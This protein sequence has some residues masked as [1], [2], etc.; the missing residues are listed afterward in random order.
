MVEKN[1][2]LVAVAGLL[3]VPM[4]QG[5]V[6][7]EYDSKIDVVR[8]ETHNANGTYRYLFTI[9]NNDTRP[10]WL[11]AVYTD[12]FE[13]RDITTS[14][15]E[16]Q[17]DDLS[18]EGLGDTWLVYLWNDDYP[19]F[20]ALDVGETATVGFTLDGRLTDPTYYAYWAQG[21][22]TIGHWTAVGVASTATGNIIPAPSALLL[23]SLGVG[24]AGGFRRRRAA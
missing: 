19:A 13:A 22:W 21:D 6:T 23:G 16:W 5:Y 7:W 14:I 1:L 24:L 8:A 2:V 3:L 12:L 4:A 15:P 20:G 10:I 11:T 9:T 18:I 17:G